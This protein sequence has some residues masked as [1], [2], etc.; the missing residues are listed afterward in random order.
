MHIQGWQVTMCDPIWHVSSRSGAV[1]VAKT[2]IHFLTLPSYRQYATP[3]VVE[4]WNRVIGC[5]SNC[6]RA[7][8]RA[9]KEI[10]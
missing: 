3:A 1:L 7:C 5:V 8:F 9:L 4:A 2:A 10:D 6:A